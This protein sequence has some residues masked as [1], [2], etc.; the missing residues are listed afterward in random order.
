M[1][2]RSPKMETAA[3]A[4]GIISLTTCSCLYVSIVCGALAILFALLSRG[5]ENTMS[6]HAKLGLI[7]GIAGLVATAIMYGFALF[8]AITEFGSLEGFLQYSYDLY[9]LDYD[10]LLNQLQ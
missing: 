9:G 1:Y 8:Y 5:G 2:K 3:L 7:L 10:E 6:S 4:L